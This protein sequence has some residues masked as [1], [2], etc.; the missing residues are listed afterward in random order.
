MNLEK[1]F[2]RTNSLFKSKDYPFIVL[3][4]SFSV[5]KKLLNFFRMG[6]FWSGDRCNA[7]NDGVC[8][9]F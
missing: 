7:R 8:Q 4:I 1:I 6:I 3:N 9:V 5:N 2:V